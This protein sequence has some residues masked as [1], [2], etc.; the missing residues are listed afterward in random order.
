VAIDAGAFVKPA[1]AKG[2]IHANRD[3]VFLSVRKK[4]GQIEAE[5][6][7]AVVIAANEIAV[8]ENQRAAEG[9]IEIEE[10]AAAQVA[11]GHIKHAPIP[12]HAGLG[13]LPAERLESV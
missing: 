2:R 12:A 10:Y 13:I 3:A 5:G 8:A 1:V 9:T 6:R 11:F 4:V 7:V